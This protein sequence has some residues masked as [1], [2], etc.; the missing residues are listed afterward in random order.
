MAAYIRQLVGCIFL[1]RDGMA[2]IRHRVGINAPR[3]R[4]Y[5]ALATV[6]GLTDGRG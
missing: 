1:R 3:E 2:G 4:V 6:R 5:E